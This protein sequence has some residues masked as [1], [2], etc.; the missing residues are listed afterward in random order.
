MMEPVLTSA[1]RFGERHERT[2]AVLGGIWF[3]ISCASWI[4]FIPIP[5][6]PYLTDEYSWVFSAAWNGLWWGFAHPLLEKHR[7]AMDDQA[8]PP[9]D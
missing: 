8:P 2:I 7:A 6:V 5:R 9:S 4:P 3:V 1:I